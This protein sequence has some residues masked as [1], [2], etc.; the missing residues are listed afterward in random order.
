M[1]NQSKRAP[2]S[3]YRV[4]RDKSAKQVHGA[5][6]N[7]TAPLT[8]SRRPKSRCSLTA[9]A[10]PLR[11]RSSNVAHSTDKTTENF[12]PLRECVPLRRPF[13]IRAVTDK[14]NSTGIF[15]FQTPKL[16]FVNTRLQSITICSQRNPTKRKRID[17]YHN[18]NHEFLFIGS[19]DQRRSE[20]GNFLSFKLYPN[21]IRHIFFF[22]S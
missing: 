4:S 2:K 5:S 1:K 21:R 11:Q 7:G 16:L 22:S 12:S 8:H 15:N 20:P 6:T 14:S 18:V 3:V 17:K 13:P 10:A 9:S 19:L